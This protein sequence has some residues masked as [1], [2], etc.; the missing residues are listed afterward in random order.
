[1]RL[2]QLRPSNIR[3]RWGKRCARCGHRGRLSEPWHGYGD[4]KVWHD[5]CM[6]ANHWRTAAEERLTVLELIAD[7]WEINAA[8][9]RE[10]ASPRG[11][12]NLESSQAWDLAWR[13]FYSLEGRKERAAV[14]GMAAE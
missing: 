14:G 2:R 9:V 12:N 10:L 13:V 4:R 11:V 5:A 6:A 1:M 8:T 3:N 7:V